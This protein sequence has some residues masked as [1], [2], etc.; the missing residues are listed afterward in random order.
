MSARR[1]QADRSATT[2][3]A[4]VLA[5]RRL[6]AEH[7]YAAVGTER[8]ASEAGVT[9]GA[10]Y[11][12]FADKVELF[13][14]VMETV[15]VELLVRL[16]HTLETVDSSD[17]R[18]VLVAGADAWLD[19]SI[20][21]EVQRIVLLD[22]PAVL[23]WERWREIGLRYALGMVTSVLAEAMRAGSIPEQPVEPLAHA[24]VG[25]LDEAALYVARAD[26]PATARAQMGAVV[27]RLV[28]GV[29]RPEC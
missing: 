21:P 6:F 13:A 4:L 17:P 10:L 16:G 8:I 22:G 19:A 7:G 28:E 18:A 27:H 2:R 26:D 15:E 12:Q 5:A 29:L 25:A 23:G 1:T 9:R 20:E 11:H 14:A 3:R 24:L